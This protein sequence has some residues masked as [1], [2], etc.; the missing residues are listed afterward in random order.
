MVDFNDLAYYVHVYIQLEFL[1]SDAKL[2]L[3]GRL[4]PCRSGR[5]ARTRP[6]GAGKDYWAGGGM[7]LHC[8]VLGKFPED[9]NRLIVI[10][11]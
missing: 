7:Y 4:S 9:I 6:D 10:Q 3:R 11:S 1:T 5:T 2:V 8:L